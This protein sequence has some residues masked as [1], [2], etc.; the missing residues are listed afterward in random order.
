M[1]SG[2]TQDFIVSL[3]PKL[4]GLSLEIQELKGGITNK[5]YRV[6]SQDGHDYV[7]RLYGQKTELFIDRDIESENL[8][9]MQP[10][11]VTP[12]LIM[13]L[14][15]KSTTV[16]EFIPGYVLKNQDFI[17][18]ELWELIIRPVK[19]IH[20]SKVTL[21]YIFD[22]LIEIKRFQKILEGINP[23]YPEF[24]VNGTI[25]VL[26]KINDI[27]RIPHSGYVPCHNDLLAENFILTED[28]QRFKEPMFL[29]DWEYGGMSP[30]HY[31]IADMFQ[32]ILVPGGVER[33]LLMIYW[34]N[35]ELNYHE[36][37]TDLLKPFPDI[38]WFL[39]S[40]IQLSISTIQFDYYEYG[41]VKYENAQK[42]INYLRDHYSVRI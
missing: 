13:Y 3:M 31:D 28:R 38:Y 7:F 8:R 34:E 37:M 29:I 2:V 36:Y 35:R 30:A 18:E 10:S 27:T 32:E 15:E 17:K 24:D 40:L 4:K 23:N 12:S 25:K 14:P 1:I 20:R 26:E 9:R 5:L 42:N 39:W 6:K 19:I 21:P 11:G 41:R 16:V 22:P 33:K